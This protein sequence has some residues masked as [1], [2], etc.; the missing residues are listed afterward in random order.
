[1]FSLGGLIPYITAIGGE[2]NFGYHK[3][4]SSSNLPL[5]PVSGVGGCVCTE[6]PAVFGSARGQLVYQQTQQSQDV[7]QGSVG[8]PNKCQPKPR[9]DLLHMRNP[10]CDIRYYQGGQTACHHLW[11]L[12]DADQDIPWTSKPITYHLKL[13]FWVQPYDS[14]YHTNVFRTTWGIASPVEYDVP[15]CGENVEGC[16]RSKDNT[17]IHTITGT[18]AGEGMLVSAHFH[19]HAPTCL[20]MGLYLCPKGSDTCDEFSG[21]LLCEEKPIYGGTGRVDLPKMDEPGYKFNQKFTSCII[22]SPRYILQPP[23]LWGSQQFGLTPP[24]NTT[25]RVLHAKKTANATIGHHGEMAW[26]QMY[27][28]V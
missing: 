15:R 2:K 1:M 22:L 8:F 26:M 19:C 4:H 16:T 7:G 9:S 3:A 24:P 12:L 27:Y 6:K 23:C 28:H 5:F 21:Q 11:S 10:T 14:N 20:S 18:F 25:N 13:R 17:W